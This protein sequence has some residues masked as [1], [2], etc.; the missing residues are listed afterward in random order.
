LN[1]QAHFIKETKKTVEGKHIK[2]RSHQRWEKKR[3]FWGGEKRKNIN[4][5]KSDKD[6]NG[7]RDQNSKTR[8]L[9]KVIQKYY[10]YGGGG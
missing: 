3:Y 10:T 7:A 1:N 6:K 2:T 8:L 4:L 5:G 9:R